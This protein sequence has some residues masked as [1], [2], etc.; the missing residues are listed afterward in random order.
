M[1][2]DLAQQAISAALTGNWD[3][4]LTIN[5]KIIKQ[6]P[7][8]VDC[9]NRLSRAYFEL[10][11]IKRAKETAQKVVA[12]DPFNTIALKSLEKWKDIKKLDKQAPI[13][14]TPQNYIE[15]PGKTKS[16]TLLHLGDPKI[17][18]KLDAGDVVNMSLRS[19]RVSIISNDLKYVGKLSDDM[20]S[21]IKKLSLQG[22]QYVVFIKST[23]KNEV[24]VFI[25]ETLRPPKFRDFPSF[26]PEKIDYIS[27]TP[28]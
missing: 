10:G 27:Y 17:L 3:N 1:Y 6:E 28:P 7:E 4:A 15:E 5:L 9:L 18:A 2:T 24:R 12:I 19:H 23:N 14:I 11:D 26:P 16:V 21:R 8:D 13:N 25:K 22:Y 20:S